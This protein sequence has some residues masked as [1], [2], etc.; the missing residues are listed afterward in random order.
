[1]GII[2]NHY[3]NQLISIIMV[4]IVT[5]DNQLT[6][7]TIWLSTI[8]YLLY[9]K[10]TSWYS[11]QSTRVFWMPFLSI[12]SSSLDTPHRLV[13]VERWRPFA[14][15]GFCSLKTPAVKANSLGSQVIG[16]SSWG[17]I[18]TH[19]ACVNPLWTGKEPMPLR[20]VY[21]KCLKVHQYVFSKVI[22]NSRRGLVV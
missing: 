16:W 5:N 10:N 13:H 9:L 22:C 3:D 17:T 7:I 15:G 1:M 21:L 11:N 12:P 18:L 20:I 14:L 8:G 6:I 2:P 4:D 19:A